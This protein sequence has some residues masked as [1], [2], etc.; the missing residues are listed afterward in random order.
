MQRDVKIGIA[1]GVLLIALI[2]VF[3]WFRHNNRNMPPMETATT[4]SE[5]ELP[6]P[7]VPVSPPMGVPGEIGPMAG[8]TGAAP[9]ATGVEPM[10]MGTVAMPAVTVVA[11]PPPPPRVAARK[12]YKVQHGDTLSSISEQFYKTTTKWKLIYDANKD[13]IGLD[14]GKLKDNME[15]EIPDA[16]AAAAGSPAP[17]PGGAH[18]AAAA[19]KYVIATG[20]TLTSIAQKSYGSATKADID[21][22]YQANKAKI[23]PDPDDLKVGMELVIPAA[24]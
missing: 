6:G 18:P 14:P 20:D 15:L 21:R 8:V 2:A 9:M 24:H 4:A 3:W 23:G 16:A 5:N 13:K 22:I 10:P 1:I 17:A 19:G 7:V 12:T 11:P